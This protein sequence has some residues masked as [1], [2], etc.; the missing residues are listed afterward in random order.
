MTELSLG[1]IVSE[2]KL[3]DWLDPALSA[4]GIELRAY[5]SDAVALA[6]LAPDLEVVLVYGD[7]DR[8]T[9]LNSIRA[10]KDALHNAS[11]VAVWPA[12]STTDARGALRAGADG[13]VPEHQID[14]S[15]ALTIDAVRSGLICIPRQ[16]RAPLESENLSAREKQ[17]LGMLV[18]GFTNAEIAGRLYLAESTVKS[19]LSSAYNKLGVRSRKDAASLIL[20]PMEGLG[21]G[22]LAISAA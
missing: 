8:G 16:M 1:A 18:M 14:T 13:L 7:G 22:I 20:D 15:L 12:T 19:H 17:V 5:A 6:R 4:A 11:L 9:L 3:H 21:P 10:A 2:A